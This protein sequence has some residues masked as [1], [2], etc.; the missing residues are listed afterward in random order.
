MNPAYKKKYRIYT[1]RIYKI[2]EVEKPK[3]NIKTSNPYSDTRKFKNTYKM[4]PT[5]QILI[6]VWPACYGSLVHIN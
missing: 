4:S 3:R 1:H 5:Q 2:P 6:M